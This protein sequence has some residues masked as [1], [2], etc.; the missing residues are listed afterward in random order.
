M[1]EVPVRHLF[2][3]WECDQSTVDQAIYETGTMH[4]R[5]SVL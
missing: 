1:F 5:S 2:T 3:A 4:F